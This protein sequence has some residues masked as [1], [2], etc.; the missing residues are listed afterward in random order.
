MT[1]ELRC[2]IWCVCTLHCMYPSM[3]RT[4]YGQTAPPISKIYTPQLCNA[5]G[6][7]LTIIWLPC[8]CVMMGIYMYI[9]VLCRSTYTSQQKLTCALI[10]RVSLRIVCAHTVNMLILLTSWCCAWQ[11]HC[12]HHGRR[13]PLHIYSTL[14]ICRFLK[15]TWCVCA[16]TTNTH[17][18]IYTHIHTRAHG[19]HTRTHHTLYT[20]TDRLAQTYTHMHM[21]IHTHTYTKSLTHSHTEGT[22][23]HTAHCNITPPQAGCPPDPIILYIPFLVNFFFNLRV[24]IKE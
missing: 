11:C 3:S 12:Q 15:C 18:I 13:A 20:R 2:V 16:H 4:H 22:H 14:A 8:A 1:V 7:S 9:Y 24:F 19:T 5:A 6:C 17:K 10:L 23:S 21:H